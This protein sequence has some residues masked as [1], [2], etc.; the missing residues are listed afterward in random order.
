[1]STDKVPYHFVKSQFAI[2]DGSFLEVIVATTM[3]ALGECR[4]P[5]PGLSTDR[6]TCGCTMVTPTYALRFRFIIVTLKIIRF[7]RETS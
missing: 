4:M 2:C 3:W 5:S 7:Y 1:V 6:T